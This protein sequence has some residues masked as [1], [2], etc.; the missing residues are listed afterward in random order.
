MHCA[1][2]RTETQSQ[3]FRQ[4]YVFTNEVTKELLMIAFDSTFPAVIS[5]SVNL[6]KKITLERAVISHEKLYVHYCISRILATL[7]AFG[8]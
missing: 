1:K 4:V 2:I 5:F 8:G 7:A 3:F 6:T